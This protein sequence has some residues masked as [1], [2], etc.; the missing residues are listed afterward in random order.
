MACANESRCKDG[1]EL[2]LVVHRGD[3]PV[4]LARLLPQPPG[5]VARRGG[6]EQPLARLDL[7]R[8]EDGR[9]HAGLR[10]GAAV[11]LVGDHQVERGVLPAW[12]SAIRGDD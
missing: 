11:R 10:A 3:L 9:E 1:A 5:V 4:G 12:A 7:R 6:H 8:V 2:L